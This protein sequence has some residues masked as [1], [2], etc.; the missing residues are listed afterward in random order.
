MHEYTWVWSNTGTRVLTVYSL[1]PRDRLQT[2][3]MGTGYCKRQSSLC[4]Y[5]LLR[6][7]PL[8]CDLSNSGHFP[9][10]LCYSG[11]DKD[12]LVVHK[13]SENRNN[14]SRFYSGC[15]IKYLLKIWKKKFK[16]HR[17]LISE[18][19]KIAIV[20]LKSPHFWTKTTAS[21]IPAW[22]PTA[23]LT[24]PFHAWLPRSDESGYFHERM[25]VAV[26]VGLINYL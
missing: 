2:T 18:N 16:K 13:K 4:C 17:Q 15:A 14:T 23:V 8:F 11:C 7:S 20:N 5:D 25:A 1:P 22:S 9:C 24:G 21:S 10:K 6:L 12:I 19:A 26:S 3:W